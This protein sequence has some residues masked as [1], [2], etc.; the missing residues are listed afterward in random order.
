MVKWLR[1]LVER[2]KYKRWLR[3]SEKL[4]KEA[5]YTILVARLAEGGSVAMKPEPRKIELKG[6]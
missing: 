1:R 3:K 2:Y 4:A 5:S 6:R